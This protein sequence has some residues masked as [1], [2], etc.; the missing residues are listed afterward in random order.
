M[1]RMISTPH[2]EARHGGHAVR[3]SLSLDGA[4]FFPE[5]GRP[6]PRYLYHGTSTYRLE[7]ILQTGLR[8]QRQVL[9]S[10]R[11]R[12]PSVH[13]ATTKKEALYWAMRAK[14]DFGGEPVVLQVDTDDPSWATVLERDPNLPFSPAWRAMDDV[15]IP[16]S[17]IKV[18][19]P[20]FEGRFIPRVKQWKRCIPLMRWRTK[21]MR[22]G[23]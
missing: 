8:G 14:E 4:T 3:A 12:H 15:V 1:R 9:R 18:C 22:G 7:G 17:S 23:F 11:L 5:I 16:P 10:W 19:Q 2:G 20:E 6:K 21:K 13:F